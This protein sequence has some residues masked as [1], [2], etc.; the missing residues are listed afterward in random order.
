M[1]MIDRAAI[2][3]LIPH[4]GSMCLLD[5]VIDWNSESIHAETDRHRAPDN[6]LRSHGQLAALHLVEY[7]AQAMALHG[8][9]AAQAAG[10]R[11]APGMLVST[12]AVKL[13][14][15]RID[16]LSSSLHIHAKRLVAS[17]GGWLYAFE[18][19]CREQRIAEGRVAVLPIVS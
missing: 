16:D 9:L 6:P 8:G 11:A 2:L 17:G 15:D 14:V 4:A 10:E 13:A 18:I 3:S 19:N 5:A 12:R 7:A 1:T